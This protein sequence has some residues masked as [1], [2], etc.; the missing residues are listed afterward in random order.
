MKPNSQGALLVA[1]GKGNFKLLGVQVNVDPATV[2]VIRFRADGTGK[3]ILSAPI[4]NDPNLGG[5]RVYMQVLAEDTGN[6]NGFSSSRGMWT[7]IAR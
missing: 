5:A 3:A 6:S 2:Q 1:A 4:A 7:G